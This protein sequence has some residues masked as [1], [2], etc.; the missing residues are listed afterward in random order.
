MNAG[1]STEHTYRA[2]SIVP[3]GLFDFRFVSPALRFAACRANYGR[4]SLRSSGRAGADSFWRVGW[5]L[6]AGHGEAHG[7]NATLPFLR[8]GK[9]G[10]RYRFWRLGARGWMLEMASATVINRALCR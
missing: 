6:E 10:W 3:P 4:A 2:D 1:A 7:Q 5:K 9:K 8:Q